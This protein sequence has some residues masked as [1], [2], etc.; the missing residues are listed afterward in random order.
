MSVLPLGLEVSEACKKAWRT[1][2]AIAN[3]K[4]A[5]KQSKYG[6][7]DAKTYFYDVY[8]HLLEEVAELIAAVEGKTWKAGIVNLTNILMEMD[9]QE[10]KMPIYELADVFNTARV[11][12]INGIVQKIWEIDQ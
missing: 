9:P 6:P 12:A 4:L 10:T 5:S 1:F 8:Y 2:D 3:S 7:I 11:A